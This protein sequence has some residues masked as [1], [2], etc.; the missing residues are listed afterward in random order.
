LHKLHVGCGTMKLGGWINADIAA[1]RQLDVVLDCRAPLPF[2]DASMQYVF[3][4]HFLEH[5]DQENGIRFLSECHRILAPASGVLRVSTPN[6]DWV[7]RTHYRYPADDESKRLGAH[8]L[9]KAFHGWGHQFL[10]NDVVLT[11]SLRL[12]G[13]KRVEFFSH[14][15][16]ELD[17]L[18]EIEQHEINSYRTTRNCPDVIIAQGYKI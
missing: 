1:H 15:A 12:A 16:S 5:L 10:Y 9:N 3:A 8:H 18:R 17:E 7:W 14:G 4:E 11:D 13:F 2:I 6:L